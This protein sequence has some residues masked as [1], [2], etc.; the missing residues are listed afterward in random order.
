MARPDGLMATIELPHVQRFKDRHGKL[1]HYFR[2]PGCKRVPLP[3][4]GSPGFLEAYEAAGLSPYQ[5]GASKA[6]HGSLSLLVAAYYASADWKALKPSTQTVYR[7]VLDRFRAD[8]G[9]LPAHRLDSGSLENVLA[10]MTDRPGAARNLLKRIRGLYAFGREKRLV[11][12][13]PTAGVSVKARKTDG[14]RP[15]TDDD[16]EKFEAHWPEGS[17]ARLALYLLLYTGQRRSDVV[18]MGRQH[19]RDGAI[20]IRQKKTGRELV[21]P[22]HAVLK[23]QLDALPKTNLTFLMTAFGKPMTEAGFTQWFVGCAKA[24]GL[25]NRSGP[26]G[27]RKAAG[28]WLAEAGCSVLEIASI[29]GHESL[30]EV[31]R[32]TKSAR[33]VELAKAAMDRMAN[34]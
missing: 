34:R 2:K 30:K 31:E 6:V 33:Q 20:H 5:A 8:F 19:V 21:I 26:H 25:P 17:R 24:A 23:A 1:R 16:I 28:R 11:S 13:D 7:N 14:F 22:L 15:W 9:D 10:K 4:P 3:D 32:Y 18:V 29:T 27:L 12:T